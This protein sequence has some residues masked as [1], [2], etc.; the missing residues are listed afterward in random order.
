MIFWFIAAVMTAAVT[1]LALW[2]LLRSRPVHL[3]S[4]AEHDVEVYA[5][6][7]RELDA[8]VARGA[9]APAEAET[10]RAEIGR[11]LLRAADRGKAQG[12]AGAAPWKRPMMLATMAAV[13][14]LV[15]LVSV[16]LYAEFG[17]GGRPDLPLAERR[18]PASAP[19]DIQTLIAGAEER[20]RAEPEDGRGWDVLAPIYLRIGRTEDA[21]TAFRN[22]IRLNGASAARESGLGEA[23]T[24]IAG[25]DVT[26]EA[27]AAFERALAQN[28]DHLPARFFLAL[29][30]SQEGRRD[31]AATAWTRLVEMSPPDAPWLEIANAAI[32]DAR[33][34][35]A[36]AAGTAP[37]AQTAPAQG[38]DGADIAAAAEMA[39]D[40]RRA[41]I[42][43]MVSQLASRLESNPDDVEGW[44]RLIR[45]YT[46]LGDADAAGAAY[47]TATQTFAPE[48]AAGREIA[49]FG[50]ELGLTAE[51]KT[52]T[53]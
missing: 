2:P 38:P 6:Q 48:S 16:A 24:Q 14:I 32:A 17:G 34:D 31:E 33:G 42:E 50:D 13:A 23:L 40:D 49:A 44:K 1:L 37:L 12:E 7:L 45:S 36:P 52:Q 47:R 27:A 22:A 53:Q 10:A 21:A 4:R 15:P 8:D 20:L 51:G 9:M 18:A 43:G 25:G 39:A 30:L 11:R 28:P 3:A 5:A 19:G 46:V 35:A 29:N 41:M 26:D